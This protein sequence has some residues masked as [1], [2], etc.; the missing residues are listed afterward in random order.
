M[1]VTPTT[2][3]LFQENAYLA[4]DETTGAAVF[5]DPGAEGERLLE[6]LRRSGARLEAIWLTH[7][8]VDHVGGIAAI[9]REHDVPVLL[10]P[11]DEPVYAAAETVARMYGIP[12]DPPPPPDAPLAEGQTVRI[13]SATFEVLHVPGHAPGHVLFV[14]DAV[15]FGGDL[16]FAGS[17]GRTDLPLSDPVA[18]QESLARAASLPEGL[19]VHPGHGPSTTIGRELRS[20]PFL[21]GAA[22]VLHGGAK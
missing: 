9:K 4:V 15:V 18:M 8:H 14:G 5:I 20:N 2:V 13:G 6:V 19:V 12:F 7:A 21:A 1:I 16:L 11:L 3:G 22:R 10:H 17:I